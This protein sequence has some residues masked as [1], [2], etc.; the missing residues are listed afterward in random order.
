MTSSRYF[1]LLLFL[2]LPA[3]TGA[4]SVFDLLHEP[5]SDEARELRIVVPMDS[6]LAKSS[7]N[8]PAQVTFTAVDGSVRQ[9]DLKVG[10][11]GKFRRQRCDYPPIKLNFSKKDLEAAGLAKWDKYK[12]VSTCAADPAFTALVLK[13]YLAYRTY[14]LL[15]DNSFRVQRLSVTYVDS[16]GNHPD[17]T[18]E[19]FLIENTDEMAHRL[20]GQ[21]LE[22]PLGQPVDAFDPEAEATHALVQYLF[23]NGDVNL[24]M[25]RNLK[26]VQLPNGDLVPV[27]YDFDFSGWVGAPY[28]SPTTEIG[29]QSIYQRVYQGY[30]Q[31]DD[32][33]RTVADHFQDRRRTVLDYLANF[34]YLNVEDRTTVQ[35]F[36]I[37]F[38]RGLNQKN[39]KT[40]TSL[41][42]QLRSGVAALIP[43]G[44]DAA[45]FRALRAR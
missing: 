9:W 38:F 27:G 2:I 40:E 21:E 25:A 43:A 1:S 20:G 19:G 39:N 8:Q 45:D 10:V 24:P 41:Y 22:N 29:Q 6:L 31:P 16:N 44:G 34:P 14:N 12:L 13:E 23:G 15:T 7:R 42:E 37:R 4:T 28:A 17:R 18:E 5:G 32:V 35:R 3:L 36:A 26:V 33:L 30:A 11:R